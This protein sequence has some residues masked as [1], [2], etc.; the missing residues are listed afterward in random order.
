MTETLPRSRP[1]ATLP[2]PLLMGAAV[3]AVILIIAVFF[4]PGRHVGFDPSTVLRS[5]LFAWIFWFGISVGS[6]G[7]V[8][9][10]HLLG[11]G[12]GY[13]IRRFGETAGAVVPVMAILFIPIILGV[14]WIYPW[15]MPDFLTTDAV[16]R[17]RA[18]FLNWPAWTIR[19][20]IYLAVFTAL[21]WSLRTTSLAHD[22]TAS[23]SLL[24]RFR[25]LSAGGEVI[26]FAVMSLASVDWIMSREPHWRST[27]FGFL[28]VI[29]QAVSAAAFLILMVRVYSDEPQLRAVLYPNYRNDLGNVLL[30]FVILWAYLSLSQFLI[31]WL[32]N[33]QDEIEWYVRR[34]DG[35][36]RLVGA[37]LILFHFLV[38]FILLLQQRLKRNLGRLAAV[39]ALVLLMRVIDV[40]YWIVPTQAHPMQP[41]LTNAFYSGVLN[42]LA[43]LSVGGIWFAAFVWMLQ[44]K[45][46][47]PVGDPIP[48]LPIT[49]G[50]GTRPHSETLD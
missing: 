6:M 46:I 25:R 35:V 40:M 47:L 18:H 24:G 13:L 1:L 21:T 22:R 3:C 16:V 27:V 12:W 36:W 38:P 28:V 32:G 5:W 19:S 31:I 9:M 45:P 42:V 29:S 34:T 2:L 50:H 33:G 10:H 23:P 4:E 41:S 14:R 15:A 43:L 8:M 37:A 49:H 26:Y 44:S 17:H 20:L 48:V 30:V 7:I 39:A 11:G